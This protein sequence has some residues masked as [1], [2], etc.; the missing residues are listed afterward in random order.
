MEIHEDPA[1]DSTMC[2]LRR[3][4]DLGFLYIQFSKANPE[5]S[6]HACT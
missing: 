2:Y 1:L 3:S 6:V 4:R 5:L